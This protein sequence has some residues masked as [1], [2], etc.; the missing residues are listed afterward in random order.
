MALIRRTLAL[1]AC[2][3][4]VVAAFP[5]NAG[6]ATATPTATPGATS[7]P[8]ATPVAPAKP[9][10]NEVSTGTAL[11]PGSWTKDPGFV[12][13]F[14][15]NAS[16]LTPQAEVEPSGVVFTG[17]PNYS[18]ATST[19]A[20]TATIK[21]SGLQNGKTYHVQVRVVNSTNQV[22]PW[23]AVSAGKFDV[24]IDQTPPSRPTIRSST[25]PAQNRWYNTLIPAFSW[26]ASDSLSGIAGYSWVIE[27]QAH[28]IPP[29]T[30]TTQTALQ[31]K[32]LAD[33]SW[34]LALRAVDR[35]GNWSATATYQVN[36]DRQ[37]PRISLLSPNRF[38]LNPYRG[39]TALRFAVS[40][41]ANVKLTLYRVG[42]KSPVST[43]TYSN[44]PGG[45]AF[46][47]Q[48]SGK[49]A[50]GK[51]LPKGYYF[52][53]A[54]VAD[55]AD[56]VTRQNLGGITLDPEAPHHAVTG[57]I[58]YPNQGKTIIVSLSHQ[59]LYAY[60]GVKLVLQT[61][62]TTGNPALP[63]PAGS[64]T[65]LAKYHPFEFISPWPEG[66]PYYYA[67]SLA[68]YAMLFRDGGYFL[69]DA[70]WRSAFGPGTNGA[71]QPGTNYG[72]THGCINIP[73]G[74]M[75][76]LWNWTPVGT[77]VLVVP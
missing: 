27:R 15:V 45:R 36:L 20:G 10:M 43:Y 9:M 77:S 76:F 26:K 28:V 44:V 59:E 75:L 32:G 18:G 22:S 56:N 4:S 74:P 24:G 41:T 67:P 58:L 19:G 8:T 7:V 5:G 31:I 6:A 61:V 62:V 29:G 69:H 23:T 30:T 25:D 66:S 16:G 13:H 68:Q 46:S 50:K 49:T 34:F 60:D 72:G 3:L 40:K 53:S 11:T 42:T 71:G 65:V 21:I 33:G 12:L 57:Q 63:T 2:T 14:G 73:P 48:W 55:R 64:F 35:A 38:T 37:A 47:L 39:G 52:F 1:L 17:T 54:S 70:P 51:P